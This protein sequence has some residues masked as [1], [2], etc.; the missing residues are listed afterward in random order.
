MLGLTKS[1]A[2]ELGP[3]GVRV[4]AI[5]PGAVVSTAE[6]PRLLATSWPNTMIGSWKTEA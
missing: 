3:H 1:L 4:N 6:A 2:R 5:A